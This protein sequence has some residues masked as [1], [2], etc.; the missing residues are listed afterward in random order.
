MSAMEDCTKSKVLAGDHTVHT[1]GKESA[2]SGMKQSPKIYD[3]QTM[4]VVQIQVIGVTRAKFTFG[5]D[6]A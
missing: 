2:G 5:E 3:D 4:V 6:L 1:R